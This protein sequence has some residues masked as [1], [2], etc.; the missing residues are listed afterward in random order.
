MALS[1][2]NQLWD[3]RD[4]VADAD[5]D[6]HRAGGDGDHLTRQRL[7]DGRCFDEEDDDVKNFKVGAEE[8]MRWRRRRRGGVASL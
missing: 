6:W 3:G 8:G 7:A 2:V 1:F 5:A 4:E